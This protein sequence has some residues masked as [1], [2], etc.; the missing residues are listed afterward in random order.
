MGRPPIG[1][2]AMT[3]T[4]RSRRY[5]SKLGTAEPATKHATKLGGDDGALAQE[6]ARAKTRIAEL[7][8]LLASRTK[9][10]ASAPGR[11]NATATATMNS[12]KAGKMI[13]KL[14]DPNDHTALVTARALAKAVDLNELA[15][16]WEKHFEKKSGPQPKK[17]KPIDWPAVGPAVTR[18]TADK[19]TVTFSNVWKALI[20][21]MPAI[22]ARGRDFKELEGLTIS[23]RAILRRLGF[24]DSSSGKIW[25]RAEP[26]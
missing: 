5:R 8:A 18:Y 17:L 12:G 1:K 11:A 26:R 21:E 16:V 9:P 6:L 15:E 24:T 20:K 25:Q 19:T 2:V 10:P 13:R 23:I 22:N 3:A 4:E 7:E 14:A